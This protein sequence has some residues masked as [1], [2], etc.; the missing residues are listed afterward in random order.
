MTLAHALLLLVA[1][2]GAGLVNGAAGGGS[3]ISFPALLAVGY[4]ALIANVTS[5]VAIW[6]GYLGGT[7][8]FSR[9][10]KDQY[11][12]IRRVAPT[13]IC[14]AVVGAVLLLTTPSTDFRRV[15]PYLILGACALFISQPS[16]TKFFRSRNA[17]GELHPAVLHVGTFCCAI[18]GSYFGAG[19]GVLLLGVLGLALPDKLVKINGL[20]AVMSL[21]INSIAVVIFVIAASVAWSAVAIMCVASLI[22]GYLGARFAKWLP[23]KVLRVLVVSLGLVAAVRL[24]TS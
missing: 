21:G 9:E 16:L 6:P 3:L 13:T 4:P 22:G 14:G 18:Y 8:G 23:A 12:R 24:L 15:A 10:I 1:G 17:G 19:L 20:R 7:A 2:L 11:D 5:T